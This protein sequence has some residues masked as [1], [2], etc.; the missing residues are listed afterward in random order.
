MLKFMYSMKLWTS[1]VVNK[2]FCKNLWTDKLKNVNVFPI[3][4]VEKY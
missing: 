3:L 1:I 4:K 2:E